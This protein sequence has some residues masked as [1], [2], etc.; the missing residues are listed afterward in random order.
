MNQNDIA[1]II[2]LIDSAEDFKPIVKRVLEVIKLYG[3]ELKE[4]TDMAIDGLSNAKMRMFKNIHNN[5]FTR[6]EALYLTINV[7]NDLSKINTKK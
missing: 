6:E 4:A 7:F 5:G 1:G 3:P 2:E